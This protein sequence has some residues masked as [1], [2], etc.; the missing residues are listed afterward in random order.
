MPSLQLPM[1][2]HDQWVIA[3]HPATVKILCKGRRWGGTVLGGTVGM[4]AATRGNT[5][6]WFVPTY[7][8]GRPLWRWAESL[9]APLRS[10]KLVDISRAE[11]HI[12]FAGGGSL[13]MF[14]ADNED[15]ARGWAFHLVVLDEAARISESCWQ[16]VIQPTLADHGGEA[17][18]I[19]SPKGRNWFWR[20][21]EACDGQ[22]Q[23]RWRAPSSANPNPRIQEA[24]ARA[25]T[26]VPERIF[27]QE[28]DAE[29]VEDGGEVFRYI[30]QAATSLPQLL[31]IPGHRYVAG[32]DWGKTID[33]T[34]LTILDTETRQMVAMERMNSI[35]YALQLRRIQAT[36]ERFG[37]ALLCAEAN[38]MGEPLIEQAIRQ[39]LPVSRFVTTNAS[40]AAIIESLAMAFEQAQLAVLNDSILLGELEAFTS[41]LLPSGLTRYSAPGGLHD[42][43]VISLA[44]A[45]SLVM[46][47]DAVSSTEDVD[48]S[49]YRA[50]RRGYQYGLA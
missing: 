6:G 8:N 45:W 20:E 4:A 28:W 9:A 23:A 5:V 37:V 14:S 43:C 50:R 27:R 38:A 22:Y 47:P 25:K 32:L 35:D 1:L 21:Y 19:S 40:K 13:G 3:V 49:H 39:G 44:L 41:V 42:D 11:Q 18:L 48:A 46:T 30:A 31:P 2:R 12:G 26:R 24:Y 33:F 10:A 36:C 29:F 34:V 7:K 17:F 15:A 16:E